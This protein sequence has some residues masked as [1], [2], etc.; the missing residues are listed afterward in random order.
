MLAEKS[1]VCYFIND[2]LYNALL[3]IICICVE[4]FIIKVPL[5]R[6][7]IDS[8]ER[9]T[10]ILRTCTINITSL[11]RAFLL[12]IQETNPLSTIHSLCKTVDPDVNRTIL[13]Q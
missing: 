10:L 7:L 5:Q 13:K 9:T 12:A 11:S 6:D 8:M 3:V 1:L 2:D 4:A